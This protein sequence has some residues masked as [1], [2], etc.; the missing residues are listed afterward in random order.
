MRAFFLGLFSV[1]ATLGTGVPAQAEPVHGIAMHGEPALP[2]DFKSFP[3]V[4]P[5]V[6]KGGTCPMVWLGP[7]TVSIHSS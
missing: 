1:L 6:K 2:A 5:D 7:S 4:K 3:Y